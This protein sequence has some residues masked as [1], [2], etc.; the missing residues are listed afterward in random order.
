MS[1]QFTPLQSL[2][3]AIRDPQ[4]CV[5][6]YRDRNVTWQQLL[7]DIHAAYCQ[8]KNSE[9][10]EW[11]LFHE[12]SYPFVVALLSLLSAGKTVYLPANNTSGTAAL[13]D[14]DGKKLIGDWPVASVNI[15]VEVRGE[16]V[17]LRALRGSIVLFTS[18]STGEPKAITKS[19]RQLDAELS[20]HEQ[21]WGA[22]WR[23]ARVLAT[24]SHQHIY[25]LLFK[26][27]GPLCSGRSFDSTIYR[28]PANLLAETAHAESIWIASPAHL[29]RLQADW[30]WRAHR[31]LMT[32]CSGGALSASAA[33]QFREL[34]GRWSIEIYGSSETGGIAQRTQEA[35]NTLWSPLPMV[36][37]QVAETLQV[38][39]P[40]LPDESWFITADQ[41]EM[42]GARF[43]LG[44]RADRIVKM[45]GK[46]VA[47]PEIEARLSAHEWMVQ[48]RAVVVERGRQR[49]GVVAEL[50]AA[51][52]QQL[53]VLGK[54]IFSQQ[55]R[56]YLQQ[57]FEPIVLPRLW[58]FESLP[59]D[60]QG[61]VSVNALS[62]LFANNEQNSQPVTL[63]IIHNRLIEPSRCALDIQ[64]PEN[65][66]Y[67][68]GHFPGVPVVP[69][70]AL[71]RWVEHFAREYLSIDG[72]CKNLEV[73]KFKQL[74]RPGDTL[75]LTLVYQ[76]DKN[77]LV[78]TF[79]SASGEHSSGR[80]CFEAACLKADDLK[81][82]GLEA[83]GGEA[84][85]G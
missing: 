61:K 63:P 69:G 33:Q 72:V 82:D 29:Q 54:H 17:P 56:I 34:S 75:T 6:R 12:E 41:A 52:K 31:L 23:N 68:Q 83:C 25:G 57:Y 2:H 70:V 80:L 48:A 7:A 67:L 58:R 27:L 51:G 76:T 62:A 14:N 38:R 43:A 8:V 22:A 77:K 3:M 32:F 44:A 64:I 50:S 85:H 65:L 71:L 59:T 30:P 74:V 78:F 1:G 81:A 60:S 16:A 10:M 79:A 13:L 21:L 73:I 42:D 49:I 4:S 9:C 36:D 28:D 55:L 45:E 47:L 20:T 11:A 66:I 5:S 40:H 26:V 84:K 15:A 35:G 18:G 19:L 37:V 24:V 46:R 53:D 39:S